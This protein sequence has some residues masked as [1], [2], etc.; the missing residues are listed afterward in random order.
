MA[1]QFRFQ[2]LLELKE[3]E[4]DQSLSEY[5]Q[6]VSEFETVAEKLY[7]NMS[8]KEL[9]EKDK[10][11]KLRTGMSVQEMRHYQQFVSNLENTIYHYQKLVIMK[12]NEMNEKQDQ[13]TE[14]NIEVKKFEKM[15]EKQFNMFAL[16]DKAAEMREMDDIS[17]KQFMIQGH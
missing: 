4:K 10:E 11:S 2:K 9:L 3:N 17:I 7:E 12:R 1:Y 8:K 16:E 6:S 14:K 15:R 13:L 5:R